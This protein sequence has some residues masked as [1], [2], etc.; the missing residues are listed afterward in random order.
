[1]HICCVAD[2]RGTLLFS[3]G[4]CSTI[5]LSLFVF[6]ARRV[7]KVTV[8]ADVPDFY[9]K[10]TVGHFSDGKTQIIVSLSGEFSILTCFFWVK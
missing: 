7:I 1:M 8:M 4:C 5:L 10:I 2:Q 9:G 3:Q 6:I